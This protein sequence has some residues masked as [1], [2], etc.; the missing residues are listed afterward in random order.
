MSLHHGFS[1][2]FYSFE[3]AIG[4]D[5]PGSLAIGL[6]NVSLRRLSRMKIIKQETSLHETAEMVAQVSGKT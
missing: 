6:G 3:F 5:L 4:D 2:A 1:S